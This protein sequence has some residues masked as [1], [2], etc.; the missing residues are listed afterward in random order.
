MLIFCFLSGWLIA[1]W[2]SYQLQIL[3]TYTTMF[4]VKSEIHVTAWIIIWRYHHF[5]WEHCRCNC[6]K[7]PYSLSLILIVC[8]DIFGTYCTYRMLQKFLY[9][10]PYLQNTYSFYHAY[11]CI[12]VHFIV[13]QISCLPFVMIC[14]VFLILS[15]LLFITHPSWNL[16]QLPV[17]NRSVE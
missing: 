10:I 7:F 2:I 17:F 4:T 13:K 15:S 5:W 12:L 11:V 8:A 3:P 9:F 14:F 6:N 1:Y 16:F